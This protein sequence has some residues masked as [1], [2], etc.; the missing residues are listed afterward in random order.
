M[1][2]TA[3]L[4]NMWEIE[5]VEQHSVLAADWVALAAD[6]VMHGRV[7]RFWGAVHAPCKGPSVRAAEVRPRSQC[8]IYA[9]SCSEGNRAT[10]GSILL[11]GQPCHF[12]II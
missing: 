1:V 4:N 2:A 5:Y 9:Q 3:N 11:G 8:C 6:W 12:R 10:L 7:I